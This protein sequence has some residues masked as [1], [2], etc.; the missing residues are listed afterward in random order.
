MSKVKWIKITTDIFNDEKMLLIESMPD[1]DTLI[2]IW[3]KLLSLAGKSNNGGLVMIS[4]TVPYTREML[5]TIFRR[6]LTVVTLALKTF[7]EFGMIEIVDQKILIRNW[8][9][10]Q[11]VKGLDDIREQNRI[12]QN[13]HR[14]K[15]KQLL[16][17]LEEKEEEQE[18]EQDIESNV[19]NNVTQSLSLPFKEIVDYLNEKTGRSFRNV[20]SNKKYIRARWNE[21]YTVDDFK[22]VI[23]NKCTEWIGTEYERY[24]QPSTLFGT[25]FDQ[26]LN[27]ITNSNDVHGD[28]WFDNYINER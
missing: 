17:N 19:T 16:L 24:L 22:K 10:H 13:K 8:E 6:K 11:N 1:S 18:R 4:D 7:E 28:D 3:F 2:V 20:E 5:A 23:D 14:E 25:K 9:K 27:Q 21:N 15:Q 12:R 26:Y